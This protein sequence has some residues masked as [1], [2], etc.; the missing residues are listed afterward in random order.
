M[1]S[2]VY[3][4]LDRLLDSRD[5]AAV[6]ARRTSAAAETTYSLGLVSRLTGLSPHVLRAWERR[7]AAVTPLRTGG[8]TRRYRESD[9]SRLRLLQAAVA[10]GHPIGDVASLHDDELRRR[11][12]VR[13]AGERPPLGEILG[14]LEGLDAA[15]AERLLGIQLAA[16]GPRRFTKSVVLPLLAEVGTRWE[17]RVLCMASEHLA[18][19]V[20]RSLL[21]A[22]L[23]RRA[24]GAPT[25][26]LL[27]TTLPG[28]RHELAVLVAAVVASDLGANAVYLGPDLPAPEVAIAARKTSA[29]AVVAGMSRFDGVATRRGALVELRKALP[30]R[31]ALWVGGAGL[32]G[33]ELPAGVEEVSSL[34]AL[35]QRVAAHVLRPASPLSR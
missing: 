32:D 28:D 10:A 34:D 9:L 8:G 33:V 17:R 21:G 18:S 30:R 24:G 20:V 25:P 19:A 16:L 27:F 3:V 22:L 11:A 35:E 23:R 12:G 7:Y 14:A 15:E 6:P 2:I 4:F 31:V 13:E 1:S 29:A 5:A 26:A